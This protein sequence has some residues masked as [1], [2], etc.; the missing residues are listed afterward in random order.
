MKKYLS[1]LALCLGVTACIYPYTPELDEAPEGVLAVDANISIGELSTVRLGTLI[2]LYPSADYKRPDLSDSKVWVEDDAG[3]NYPGK[4]GSPYYGDNPYYDGYSALISS[5]Y[6]PS[7]PVYYIPTEDAPGDRR[8]RLCIEALGATYTSDWTDLGEPPVIQD[9]QFLADEENV[10]VG[11]TL[12]GGSDATGYALLSF[13]ETWRFHVDYIPMYTVTPLGGDSFRITETGPD[14]SKYWCWKT[15]DNRRA[16]PVDYT[17]MTTDGVTNWP[18]QRFPR[19]DN[20][21]H[22]RY[23]INVKAR[24]ISKSTYRFLKNLEDTSSGGDNL[25]SPTPG[26]IAS[27]LHCESEPD[28]M[29]LGYVIFSKSVSKRAWM[30]NRFHKGR[31]NYYT[32]FYLL[33]EYYK[34]Y[35]EAG[36]TVLDKTDNPREGEGEYGWGPAQCYDCTAA[37]GT[38]TRPV[39]W[40]D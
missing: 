27:N 25:F 32:L 5:Y 9:I 1:I 36:Y 33:P 10:T 24:T 20:R 40:E 7:N 30:D 14:D 8:Y 23:T 17:S 13:D 6:D 37:G 2:S 31:H 22:K 38:L 35:Y 18:L 29:V 26:E 19:S 15:Q 21:N 4:I 16:F 34:I 39:Y 12:E 11:V 3:G 28:R